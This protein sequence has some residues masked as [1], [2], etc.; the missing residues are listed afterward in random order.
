MQGNKKHGTGGRLIRTAG[1]RSRA[2]VTAAGRGFYCVRGAVFL[3]PQQGQQAAIFQRYRGQR[4][5]RY[6]FRRGAV[7]VLQG[8]FIGCSDRGRV[9][10]GIVKRCPVI[11]S[12][13]LYPV[14]ACI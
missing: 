14:Y 6:Q 2:T 1:N 3:T 7:P 4:L 10:C 8:A 9:F 11:V 13:V 12:P 5:Q